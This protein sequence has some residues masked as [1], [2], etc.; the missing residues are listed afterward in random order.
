M[1][2]AGQRLASSRL[3]WLATGPYR[4]H[5]P[6]TIIP[7]KTEPLLPWT[8]SHIFFSC[9]YPRFVYYK[10]TSTSQR[11]H[12]NARHTFHTT[13]PS[14]EYGPRTMAKFLTTP[15]L[16]NN[17]L[18]PVT[19]ARFLSAPVTCNLRKMLW[20]WECSLSILFVYN[21]CY[22][23]SQSRP[24]ARVTRRNKVKMY[25]NK[26]TGKLWISFHGH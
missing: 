14:D 24:F 26:Q 1:K 23:V 5:W 11:P 21:N 13:S 3:F 15:V 25:L 16:T 6:C 10:L 17:S 9:R 20:T 4:Q 7:L 18:A 22:Y 19:S 2:V 12:L 8:H